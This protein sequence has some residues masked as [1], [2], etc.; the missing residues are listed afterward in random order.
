[1]G[2]TALSAGIQLLPSRLCMS[3]EGIS[4]S[5]KRLNA[6]NLNDCVDFFKLVGLGDGICNKNSN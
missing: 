1:M 4:N 5:S 6:I 3:V 2:I